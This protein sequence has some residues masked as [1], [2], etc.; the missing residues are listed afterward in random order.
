[1]CYTEGNVHNE[2]DNRGCKSTD[3]DKHNHSKLQSWNMP[4]TI[5]PNNDMQVK[6]NDGEN[7]RQGSPGSG[8]IVLINF[9]KRHTATYSYAC[10]NKSCNDSY[11]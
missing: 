8:I 5:L 2:V 4:L 3:T 6:K 9:S 11:H 7:S 10:S 1:M